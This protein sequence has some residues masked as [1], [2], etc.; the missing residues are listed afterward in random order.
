MTLIGFLPLRAF[1]CSAAKNHFAIPAEFP[2]MP[3]ERLE[4]DE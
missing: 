2:G 3:F 4:P 1:G